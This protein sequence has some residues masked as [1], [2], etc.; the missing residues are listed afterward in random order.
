MG[1]GVCPGQPLFVCELG[2]FGPLTK[3][4]QVGLYYRVTLVRKE[5]FDGASDFVFEASDL[6]F[7]DQ[8][9]QKHNVGG[10]WVIDLD[11]N[12]LHVDEVIM[13][14]FSDGVVNIDQ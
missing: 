7:I 14:A 12:L 8:C 13:P 6:E 5:T 9:P 3:G 4:Q 10:L 2:N 1:V 11:Q